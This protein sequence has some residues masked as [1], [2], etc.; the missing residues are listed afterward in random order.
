MPTSKH[1]S[2]QV[3]R[4]RPVHNLKVFQLSSDF[5]CHCISQ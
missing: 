2:S 5:N 4:V 3:I 1:Q